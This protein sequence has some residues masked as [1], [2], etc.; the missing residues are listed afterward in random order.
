[1]WAALN[2]LCTVLAFCL[3][4]VVYRTRKFLRAYEDGLRFLGLTPGFML[5]YFLSVRNRTKYREV[6]TERYFESKAILLRLL[7]FHIE[8]DPK[9]PAT[10]SDRLAAGSLEDLISFEINK[11]TDG[12]VWLSFFKNF[13]H[14][15]IWIASLPM[16]LKEAPETVYYSCVKLL[17]IERWVLPKRLQGADSS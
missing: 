5:Q 10:D 16:C 15:N 3:V 11:A 4:I 14:E 7:R 13:P 6:I 17:F 1:M 2:I 8:E 12:D 9:N